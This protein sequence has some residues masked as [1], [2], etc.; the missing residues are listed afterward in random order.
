MKKSLLVIAAILMIAAGVVYL[1]IGDP[2][3][4]VNTQDMNR[5]M[6]NTKDGEITFNELTEFDWDTMY[7]FEGNFDSYRIEE[8]IG[9]DSSAVKSNSKE[10]S[11]QVIFVNDAKVV[12]NLNGTSR[13]LGYDVV[14]ND[15]NVKCHKVQNPDN[16]KFKV[17]EVEG[18]LHFTEVDMGIVIPDDKKT[19]IY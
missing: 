4:F 18:I 6:L 19:G 10:E 2:N 11:F 7:V 16:V 14:F 12:C 1:V 3:V 17:T 9:F 15:T 5:N 8:I 13:S